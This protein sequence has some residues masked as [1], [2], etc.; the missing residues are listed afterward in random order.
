[1]A[2]ETEIMNLARMMALAIH[3]DALLTSGEARSFA[4]LARVA[5]VSTSRISQIMKLLDLAPGIQEQLLFAVPDTLQ[6]SEIRL[7]KIA[8][9]IDWRKQEE[10]FAAARG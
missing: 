3:F 6:L 8:N 7:R 4:A 9:E 10:A 5:N 1:M 2:A